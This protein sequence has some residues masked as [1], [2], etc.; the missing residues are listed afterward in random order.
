MKLSSRALCYL[1]AQPR[2]HRVPPR[3][4]SIKFPQSLTA[5]DSSGWSAAGPGPVPQVGA[6]SPPPG[7]T[8]R[9]RP[10]PPPLPFIFVGRLKEETCNAP[11]FPI[12]RVE[13][14]QPR[15]EH[16][17]KA[18]QR[19]E[20]RAPRPPDP[21]ARCGAVPP[22]ALSGPAERRARN[23]QPAGGLRAAARPGRAAPP[24]E[25]RGDTPPPVPPAL[26]PALLPFLR[27]LREPGTAAAA[28]PCVRN[29]AAPRRRVPP[30]APGRRGRGRRG[31]GALRGAGRH[32]G[33][34]K[35][36]TLSAPL[37]PAPWWRRW[38]FYL[39]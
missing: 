24:G 14:S 11:N 20:R 37:P 16:E 2:Q 34:E 19:C 23:P 30:R 29:P 38:E 21:E 5:A 39:E 33:E 4:A 22:P 27:R 28:A 32:R 17:C 36:Y 31:R 3:S 12:I 18:P 15:G 7:S 10:L 8:A 13:T 6:G 35:V 26:P 9:P 25:G 1:A